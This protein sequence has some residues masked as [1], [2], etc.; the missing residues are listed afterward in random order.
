MTIDKT[1]FVLCGTWN[2]GKTTTITKTR[3][4]L[5]KLPESNEVE[6]KLNS[7]D[8]TCIIEV[9]GIH[10][11][12]VSDGDEPG[13]VKNAIK[14]FKNKNCYIIIC[15]CHTKNTKNSAKNHIV[16][17][18]GG[19]NFCWFRTFTIRNDQW[20]AN[21]KEIVCKAYNHGTAKVIVG[22]VKNRINPN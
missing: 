18:C 17:L 21:E 3:D 15:A 10:I 5:L 13:N 8:F 1:V 12:I 2:T 16:T 20:L 4:L 9:G 11:G 22:M 6:Y 19:Y 7:S 14:S